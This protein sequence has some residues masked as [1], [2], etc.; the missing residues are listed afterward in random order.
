VSLL[1]YGFKVASAEQRLHMLTKLL[2]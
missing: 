2:C 1:F